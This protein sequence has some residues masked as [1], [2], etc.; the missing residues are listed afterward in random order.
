VIV[1]GSQA[2]VPQGFKFAGNGL[3][4]FGLGNLFFDQNES[5]VFRRAF[6]DRHIFYQGHYLGI[7]LFPI[8]LEEFGK[9]VPMRREEREKFLEAILSASNW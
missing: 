5:S 2:H 4:H 6:V 3:I 1:S 7:D 8:R 9:P